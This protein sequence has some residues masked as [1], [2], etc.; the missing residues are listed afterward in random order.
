MLLASVLLCLE[1]KSLLQSPHKSM[2][3]TRFRRLL[4][5]V[6]QIVELL[7]IIYCL[8]ELA[9]FAAFIA[10]RYNAPDLVRPYRVPL[11]TW[12]CIIMLLPASLLLLIIL[13]LPIYQGNWT[14]SLCYPS[15][16]HRFLS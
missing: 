16:H 13:G 4:L 3:L 1:R 11:P 2:E 8:A 5:L 9:E 12:A 6:M 14:V 10:L 7:N 15:K